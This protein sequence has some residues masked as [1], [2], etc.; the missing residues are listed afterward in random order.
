[1]QRHTI[2]VIQ[3]A[4]GAVVMAAALTGCILDGGGTPRPRTDGTCFLGGCAAE[5]CSDRADVITP[6]IWRDAFACF[7]D[8][9]CERQAD[10]ACGWTQTAELEA[11]LA[12]HDLAP[13][14]AP[15]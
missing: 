4:A 6:C 3:L 15:Q 12:S 11:C 9:R 7:H 5:V 1:M 13:D 10:G 8:A 2:S 14:P